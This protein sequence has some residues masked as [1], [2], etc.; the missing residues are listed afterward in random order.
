M[1][2]SAI[3]LVLWGIASAG[4][5]SPPHPFLLF[6]TDD[7]PSLRARASSA[8]LLAD[9][10][11]NMQAA[12]SQTRPST[13]YPAPGWTDILE[14]R[15]FLAALGNDPTGRLQAVELLLTDLRGHDPAVFFNKADF[16]ELAQPLRAF[17]LAWDW[18]EPNMTAA[19]RAEALPGLEHWCIA[20][21][22]QTDAAW[23]RE[24]SYNVGAIPVSGYGLLA[25][26]I[27]GDSTNARVAAC[28][29]EAFRR[30]AQNYFPMTWRPSGICFEGPNYAIVG[31]R[32]A[33]VF[34]YANAR[35]GGD[36][37]L[38]S[39]G[40]LNG[41][42]YLMH[43]Y[44]PWGGCASI[45]DN[46]DYG[47]RTFAAEYLLGLGR[48][49]D[50]EGFRT[51]LRYARLQDLDPL[52]TY[53][54]YPLDLVPADPAQ[55]KLPTSRYFEVAPNRAG[56]V[57][58]RTAWNDPKA[59]FFAFVT[60]Y[61]RCNHQHYD[62]DSF[63][64]GGFGRLF[65]THRMLYPY[66]SDKHGVDYEH[67]LVIVNGGGWPRANRTASC[68]D[69]NSTEGVLVGLVLSGFADYV[70]GDAKWSYRDNAV[71]ISDPAI[72]AERACLFVKHAD[73]P[74]LL[75]LDDLEQS[76]TATKYEWLWHAPR[77]P[78]SGTGT[79]DDP[80][81]MAASNVS[82][83][84]QFAVPLKPVV[85]SEVTKREDEKGKVKDTPLMRLRVAQTGLRVR[86][87]ALATLQTNLAMRPGV[88]LL[89][90]EC[91]TPAAGGLSVRL[92]DG[93]E[94]FIVWQ[95]EEEHLQRG[96]PLSAGRLR[97]DGLLAMVRVE[98]GA[99]TG[100]V[101][102]EG[103]YLQWDD[104]LLVRSPASVCVSA[105]AGDRQVL[106]RR[107]SRENMPTEPPAGVELASLP[108][109][110]SPQGKKDER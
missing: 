36:D 28:H 11:S 98:H 30:I 44:L 97:T 76:N 62:M 88:A 7:L 55:T 40:V 9:C 47:P 41:V 26:S 73:T 43:Q 64:F 13:N 34:A 104:K 8:P 24:A 96:T 84:I 19:Q 45:G 10:Y 38:A 95:S 80:L 27:R 51:W 22:K 106:G 68:F 91:Q 4:L 101:L 92:A 102:G 74:Y 94:D 85:T 99:V 54:W 108:V 77:L 100:F 93:A 20:A 3:L 70:R 2:L 89:P 103:T 67:N 50:A 39:S 48:L 35:A 82:C 87:A 90:V 71:W 79:L 23:W 60:R 105:G 32:Y 17:A 75:V 69:D 78:L 58:S 33:S 57:F 56:Y 107:R 63:L 25:L 59:A 49:R 16:H 15:A 37:V 110:C 5:A 1:R 31:Y 6:S 109:P 29:R 18:L 83:A 52:I 61:D 53:L 14:A 42:S 66:P 46:T 72:R 12:A 21:H 86:Y 65:A 81:V